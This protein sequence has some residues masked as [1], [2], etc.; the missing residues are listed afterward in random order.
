MNKPNPFLLA[1][2]NLFLVALLAGACGGEFD[3]FPEDL[4]EDD[5]AGTTFD[6]TIAISFGGSEAS[7]SG[8]AHGIV[9][10]SGND[11]IVD[12]TTE[13]VIVY[14]LSGSTD[15]GSFK[16]YSS[17][18]QAIQLRQLDLTNPTGAAINNQSKKRTFV[19]VEGSNSLA[20]GA[21]YTG[22]KGEDEKAAFFSEGQL[23]FSGTGTLT[24]T[25]RGKAGITSDDYV[26]FMASPTIKVNTSAGHAVCGKEAIIVSDGKLDVTT[27]ADMKKG[28][29][30]DSLVRIDGGVTKISVTGSTAYDKKDKKDTGTAGIKADKLFEM[31][32]GDLV[33]HNSGTGGKG[34]SG[35]GPGYFK[36]GTVSIT[37]SGANYGSS[38]S[39]PSKG[40][41]FDGDLSFSGTILNVTSRSHEGISSKGTIDIS[42][43]VL[44]ICAFDDAINA[45]GDMT[46]NGGYV[47]AW[48]TDNDGLDAN[49]NLY[50]KGGTVYAIGTGTPEVGMDANTDDAFKLYVQGGTLISIGGL[51]SEAVL[52]Q[53]CYWTNWSKDTWYGLTV[54]LS[55]FAFKTPSSGGDT[56]VV[57]GVPAPSLRSGVSVSGGTKLF[58]GIGVKDASVSGGT[59]VT[60]LNYTSGR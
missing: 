30:S 29:S 35:D 10:V 42:G 25:A 46:I 38:N 12:N 6:R 17:K 31:L 54:G 16:L 39:T 20:D 49:G 9:S 15:R 18:K 23:V 32:D 14:L 13:E 4:D 57:S 28:F 11:V 48:S 53:P 1:V 47:C 40:I 50:V 60:L 33:I 52:S 21:S 7:V 34:I 56:L 43:G 8:D 58:N 22:T 51:E 3:P 5:V 24:V 36:G 19:V 59:S 55:T 27:S 45:A 26:R 41:K 44:Y 2:V 37:T